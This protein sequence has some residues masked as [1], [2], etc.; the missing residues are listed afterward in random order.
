[1]KAMQ[2][3]YNDYYQLAQRLLTPLTAV[4][5]NVAVRL[6]MEKRGI[7]RRLYDYRCRA[8]VHSL[9]ALQ[10]DALCYVTTV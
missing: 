10:M 2:I 7:E 1:M 3:T 8:A 6:M 5:D 4:D 9:R